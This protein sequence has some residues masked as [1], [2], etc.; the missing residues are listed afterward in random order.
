MDGPD[1]PIIA[2]AIGDPA[3]IGPEI[4]LKTALD[5]AVRA[6]C[7]PI[8]VCDPRILA[9]HA[10]SCGINTELHPIKRIADADWSGA[11]INVLDCQVADAATL[12]VGTTSAAAGAASIAFCGASIK[13]ALAGDVD[14]VVAAPQNETSIA[15][16]GTLPGPM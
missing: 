9:R 3:G 12:A 5:P 16:A 14:A 8:V 13:A 4:S 7:N 1:K 15:A 10:K 11:R 6:V 2:I